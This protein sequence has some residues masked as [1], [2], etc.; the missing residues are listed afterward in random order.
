M[1]PKGPQL[2]GD[3]G[4]TRIYIARGTSGDASPQSIAVNSCYLRCLRVLSMFS[5]LAITVSMQRTRAWRLQLP[6]MMVQGA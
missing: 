5:M 4:F 2:R 6:S 1:A 3:G